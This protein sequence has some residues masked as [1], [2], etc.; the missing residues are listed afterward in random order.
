[1]VRRSAIDCLAVY[2][3]DCT[4]MSFLCHHESVRRNKGYVGKY[5]DK[6]W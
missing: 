2:E 3:I 6:L 1:M 4:D 5:R